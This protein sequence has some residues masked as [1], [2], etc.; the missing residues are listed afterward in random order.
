LAAATL[1]R[2]GL[3]TYA[4]GRVTVDANPDS[5]DAGRTTFTPG[6]GHHRVATDVDVG[7]FF[8]EYFGV[9]E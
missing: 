4:D 8:E 5:P 3:C 9:F 1:F 6:A 2:S 7:A